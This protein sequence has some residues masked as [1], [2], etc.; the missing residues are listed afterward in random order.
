MIMSKCGPFISGENAIVRITRVDECGRPIAGED[1]GLVDDCFATLASAPQTDTPA[2]REFPGPGGR[3]CFT[4]PSC[5]DYRGE[6]ITVTGSSFRNEIIEFMTGN[7]PRLN[8]N[9]DPVGFS[10]QGVQCHIGFA[11]EL[12]V[13]GAGQDLCSEEGSVARQ[14]ILY[15]WLVNG[16]FSVEGGWLDE[17]VT[18]QITARTRERSLWGSGPY[19]VEDQDGMGTAGPLVEPI[20]ADDHYIVQTVTIPPPEASCDLITV[21]ALSS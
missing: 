13:E 10:V 15:P 6:E 20:T 11:L 17:V 3:P 1:N 14:Y 9:G 4:L 12:W 8:W 18:W 5:P 2:D 19:D 21:P 7:P 16:M